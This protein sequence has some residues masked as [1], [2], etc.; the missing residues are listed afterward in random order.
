M[1]QI[2]VTVVIVNYNTYKLTKSAIESVLKFTKEVDFE[3]IVVDNASTDKSAEFLQKQFPKV[4]FIEN[5]EN[6]GFGKA[7]NQGFKKA[8]G[9]YVFLLNSDA[10][11]VENS[12]KK[13]LI[14][15]KKENAVIIA[16]KI[17]NHDYSLQQSYGGFPTLWNT[18]TW[19]FFVDDLPI[20]S[21]LVGS[22]HTRSASKYKK[23]KMV[24]WVTGACFMMKKGA[25]E[26]DEAIFMYGEDVELCYQ[27]HKKN[28]NIL[29]SP[30]TKVVHL[31]SGGLE[32]FVERP[33]VSEIE[34]L[35]YFYKKHFPKKWTSE[36]II[37]KIGIA[38]RAVIFGLILRRKNA[39]DIYVKAFQVA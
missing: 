24:D 2:D 20:I 27:V 9:E 39:F 6:L 5:K 23:E 21:M 17:V 36:R 28:G 37:I 12:I 33:L 32:G 34:A 16:P 3:I 29:Y 11:L 18:F 14:R 19:M 8:Q 26:F 31:G 22:F 1:S 38:L 35:K 25:G 4:I 13:L 10:Y 15:I 30:T 7:N